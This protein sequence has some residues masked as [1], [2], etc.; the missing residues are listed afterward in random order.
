[1][2]SDVALLVAPALACADCLLEGA[3]FD[4]FNFTFPNFD[5][6]GWVAMV[7]GALAAIMAIIGLILEVIGILKA[8]AK[9]IAD[10][11]KKIIKLLKD[12][13]T[14]VIQLIIAAVL[15]WLISKIP[16]LPS[17]NLSLV[18]L[19]GITIPGFG[20]FDIPGLPIDIPPPGLNLPKIPFPDLPGF[21]SFDIPGTFPP[22]WL[23]GI[24]MSLAAIIAFIM[25]IIALPFMIIKMI[26]EFLKKI[27]LK[28]PS[29]GTL[30]SWLLKLF[31]ISGMPGWAM[32][33]MVKCL[34][35]A[36]FIL[37]TEK[38]VV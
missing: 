8:A 22:D 19:N 36:V 15:A 37:L 28:I 2:S 12:L 33:K 24:G 14:A 20:D 29:I 38:L 10:F 23:S 6:P 13:K 25:A 9:K 21:P 26:L 11:I 7:I 3:G 1:M 31:G 30:I 4:G 35:K 18:G 27:V 32:S 16:K 17:L 5:E 34:A